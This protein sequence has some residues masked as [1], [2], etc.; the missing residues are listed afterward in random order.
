MKEK[1]LGGLETFAKAMVQPLMYLS[2]AGILMVIGV[3]LTND[4]LTGVI[5]FL[6]WEPI[7]IFGDLI[8]NCVMA[9]I[10]NLSVIFAIGIPAALAKKEKHKAALIGFMSY[11]IY[12]TTSNTIL[13]AL[14]Q[15]AEPSCR[16]KC[17]WWYYFRLYNRIYI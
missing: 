1:L 9:I 5:P 3:L 6:K 8:Y 17:I 14:E 15:L 7:Q 12:L 13:T 10:N 11:F 16:Y 4:I 2:S